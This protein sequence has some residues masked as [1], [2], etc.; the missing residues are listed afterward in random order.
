MQSP[1]NYLS[2]PAYIPG[3][4]QTPIGSNQYGAGNI[5]TPMYQGS[6]YYAQSMHGAQSPAYSPTVDNR[7]AT[8]GSAAY[9]PSNVISPGTRNSPAY[10]PYQGSSNYASNAGG[11]NYAPDSHHVYSSPHYSPASNTYGSRYGSNYGAQSSSPRYGGG[12]N[13]D[14]ASS[15]GARQGFQPTSPIY[16]P[17]S[18]V[19]N[20]VQA[21]AY[22]PVQEDEEDDE[23]TKKN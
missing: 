12:S 9:S 8:A 13:Y 21:N 1:Y 22:Q 23:E 16:N 20:P 11:S 7:P 14:P 10:S 17:T 18:P 6:S 3:G 4:A 19:Y 5:R 2:T 15:D